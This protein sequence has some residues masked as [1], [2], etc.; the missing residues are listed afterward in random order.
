VLVGRVSACTAA[1]GLV[2]GAESPNRDVLRTE[3]AEI[4]PI[5]LGGG[6]VEEGWVGAVAPLD[7]DLSSDLGVPSVVRSVP[8]A[9]SVGSFWARWVPVSSLDFPNIRS[10]PVM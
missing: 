4:M 6:V 7:E 10:I 8:S 3:G 5:R 2:D 1:A 9:L